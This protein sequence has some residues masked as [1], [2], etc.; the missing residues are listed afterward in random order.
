[1][2]TYICMHAVLY[3]NSHTAAIESMNGE[4]DIYMYVYMCIYFDVCKIRKPWICVKFIYMK[5]IYRCHGVR[6]RWQWVLL[7]KMWN[8]ACSHMDEQMWSLWMSS[9]IG[10]V[11]EDSECCLPRCGIPPALTWMNK[12]MWSLWVSSWIRFVKEDSECCF[13]NVWNTTCKRMNKKKM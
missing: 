4:G 8:T 5:F 2:P 11:K 7:A 1:M 12:K 13:A 10:F 9:W 3:V 6:E